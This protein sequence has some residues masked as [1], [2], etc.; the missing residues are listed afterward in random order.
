MGTSR[1]KWIIASAAFLIALLVAFYFVLAYLVK[2][3]WVKNRAISEINKALGGTVQF[4]ETSLIIFPRLCLRISDIKFDRPDTATGTVKTV[5]ICP[6]IWTLFKGEFRIASAVLDEPD[7][8]TAPPARKEKPFPPEMIRTKIIPVLI[9]AS[10]RS[11]G[12]TLKVINGRLN[13][14]RAGG[15][16]FVFS[17]IN[18]ETGINREEMYLDLQSAESPWGSLLV[19]GHFPYA[20]D[21][22]AAKGLKASAGGC[23]I[24]GSEASLAWENDVPVLA[25]DV[26]QAVID[27]KNLQDWGVFS[28]LRKGL[29][30][31]VNSI[32][33]RINLATVHIEGPLQEPSQWNYSFSGDLDRVALHTPF[34]P[35]AVKLDTGRF[36]AAHDSQAARESEMEVIGIQGSIG[37]SSFENVSARLKG[38][39]E[40]T[41]FHAGADSVAL[42]IDEIQKWHA[43]QDFRKKSIPGLVSLKG[44]ARVGKLEAEGPVNRPARWKY[45]LSGSLEDIALDFSGMPYLFEVPKGEFSATGSAS[46]KTLSFAGASGRFGNSSISGVSGKF[47]TDGT[48]R[49]ELSGGSSRLALSELEEWEVV[50]DRLGPVTSL[51]GSVLLDSF[52]FTGALTDPETWAF[53]TTG[54]A[55]KVTVEIEEFPKSRI[56]GRFS[57]DQNTLSLEKA[58]ASLLD[59]DVGLTGQ[60]RIAENKFYSAVFDIEG[61][62]GRDTLNW[63]SQYKPFPEYVKVPASIA[64]VDSHLEWRGSDQFS[65]RGLFTPE[66]G[67]RIALDLARSPE[68][69]DVR[70]LRLKDEKSDARFSVKIAREGMDFTYSGDLHKSTVDAL[71]FNELEENAFISGKLTGHIPVKNPILASI[72]GRV[73]AEDILVPLKS[74]SYPLKINSITVK[75]DPDNYL[76]ESAGLSWGNQ[77]LT[78]TGTIKRTGESLLVN[79]NV[80]TDQIVY[81]RLEAMIADMQ[82]AAKGPETKPSA[83]WELPLRGNITVS[84]DRFIIKRFAAE[85]FSADIILGPRLVRLNFTKDDVCSVPLPGNID[86][87]PVGNGMNFHSSVAGKDLA[88]ALACLMAQQTAASGTFDF[89]GEVTA[90]GKFSETLTGEFTFT[91]RKG[92]IY[93]ARLLS[94]ILEYLNIT[95]IFLGRLPTI[96]AEGLPYRYFSIKGRIKGSIIEITEFEL[97]GPTLGLAGEGFIDLARDRV[98]MTVLVSPLRTF[99]YLISHI[100][101]VKY[102]F[103]G[104]LAIP[105]GVYGNPSS[106]II[107]PLDPSAIGA[108]LLSIMNRIITAP[109]KLFESFK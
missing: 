84:A 71:V 25:A 62:I 108:Q 74:S 21:R 70:E 93:R 4:G 18:L 26:D 20:Q 42:N 68:S 53:A 83:F 72:T 101:I 22:L 56:D 64:V 100:P 88:P 43:F 99:D 106:P 40:E 80:L 24:S 81:E 38:A 107:V 16:P 6:Q 96:G 2:T 90:L 9:D 39:G 50:Y 76:V 58:R 34:V 79:L 69:W 55:R 87:T 27:L 104:I 51:E 15:S 48:P 17:G 82:A 63:A 89:Q 97:R 32:D 1:K 73:K 47:R 30:K 77:D 14:Q 60:L 5:E 92:M 10:S 44:A 78:A 19:Q 8:I 23:S 52:R 67:P 59:T 86:I 29:L 33:G 13:L 66:A 12:A 3:E 75:A 61:K 65:V 103:K 105:V 102:F 35:Q 98:E 109:L 49:L 11:P 45:A 94:S 46:E 95:Q 28:I 37:K 85:P 36:S 41:Y 31:N 7:I 54:T 91:A 57:L